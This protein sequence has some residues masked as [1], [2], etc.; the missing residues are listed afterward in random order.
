MK[1]DKP[2]DLAALA[3]ELNKNLQ[4]EKGPKMAELA[5]QHRQR[6]RF[7][8][9]VGEIELKHLGRLEHEDIFAAIIEE[10]PLYAETSERVGELKELKK[11]PGGIPESM[12]EEKNRVYTHCAKYS[13]RYYLP[14]F[15]RPEFKNSA[16]FDDFAE[17]LLPDEWDALRLMM[18]VLTS[19]APSLNKNIGMLLVMAGFGIKLANDL[20]MENMTL[21]QAQVYIQA[22]NDREEDAKE[23]LAELARRKE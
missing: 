17:G 22:N 14:C 10:D 7:K 15:V 11:H 5:V 19:E 3:A 23:A 20:T 4:G 13:H 8:T 16:E 2:L 1:D 12:K 9:S 6:F 18:N 21:Q